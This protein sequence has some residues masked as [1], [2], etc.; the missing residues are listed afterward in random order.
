MITPPAGAEDA[1]EFAD[2]GGGVGDV[3]DAEGDGDDVGGCVG[4]GEGLGVAVDEARRFVGCDVLM[5]RGSTI[6]R[7]PF[8]ERSGA[9]RY[10]KSIPRHVAD[11]WRLAVDRVRLTEPAENV[12]RQV[13]G[14]ARDVHDLRRAAS[15]SASFTAF[16]RHR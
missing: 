1:V 3:A 11:A 16:R 15:S 12:E 14:P 8:A 10:V 9:S 2:G 7:W 13:A 4:E 6:M 5:R